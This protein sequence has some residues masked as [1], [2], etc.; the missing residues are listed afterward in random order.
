VSLSRQHFQALA[1]ALYD[2]RP[3]RYG[4]V[5][6]QGCADGLAVAWSQWRDTRNHVATALRRFNSSFDRD[7]FDYWSEHGESEASTRRK[8]K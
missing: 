1:D 4:Q 3:G 6:A 7:R 5:V 2:S 8:R